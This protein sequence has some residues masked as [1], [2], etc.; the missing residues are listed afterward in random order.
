MAAPLHADQAGG[1]GG[2][3]DQEGGTLSANV[4][5]SAKKYRV[6]GVTWYARP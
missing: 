2:G 6:N 4:M 1:E 3:G 5:P